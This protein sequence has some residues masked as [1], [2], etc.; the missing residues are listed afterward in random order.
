MR[1][2][3]LSLL[4]RWTALAVLAACLTP[5][6]GAL[7]VSLHVLLEHSH[8]QR[9]SAASEPATVPR[10]LALDLAHGHRHATAEPEHEHRATMNGTPLA[11]GATAVALAPTALEPST[12]P[13]ASIASFGARRRAPPGPLFLSHG[14]LLL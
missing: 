13:S 14:S 6:V 2:V 3:P 7:A 12:P 9:Q 8:H 10:D 1:A 11:L 4:R 5:A